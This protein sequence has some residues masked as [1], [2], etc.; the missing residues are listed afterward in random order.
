M[1]FRAQS[2]LLSSITTPLTQRHQQQQP[3]S[4]LVARVVE[5]FSSIFRTASVVADDQVFEG[6]RELMRL[7]EFLVI[8]RKLRELLKVGDVMPDGSV[9]TLAG[10]QPARDWFHLKER[11]RS[12]NM[13]A[14]G[15][16][17]EGAFLDRWCSI[18]LSPGRGWSVDDREACRAIVESL[19]EFS[20]KSDPTSNGGLGADDRRRAD[21]GQAVASTAAGVRALYRSTVHS[22]FRSDEAREKWDKLCEEVDARFPNPPE[23]LRQ[24]EELQVLGMELFYEDAQRAKWQFD[25]FARRL[26]HLTRAKYIPLELPPRHKVVEN[27]RLF[28]ANNLLTMLDIV[29]GA[30]QFTTL[31]GFLSGMRLLMSEEEFDR[32]DLCLVGVRNTINDYL[33]ASAQVPSISSWKPPCLEL[34]VR[35][36]QFV[37]C[38]E[39]H[40]PSLWAIRSHQAV[41]AYK[42]L[43][44]KE[45]A[46][47][48]ATLD[49]DTPLAEGIIRHTPAIVVDEVRQLPSG[50]TTIHFAAWHGNLRLC[51]HLLAKGADVFEKVTSEGLMPFALALERGHLDVAKLLLD[52]AIREYRYQ[53]RHLVYEY[54]SKTLQALDAMMDW[55]IGRSSLQRGEIVRFTRVSE[56]GDKATDA[57]RASNGVGFQLRGRRG[58]VVSLTKDARGPISGFGRSPRKDPKIEMASFT[59]HVAPHYAPF[60]KLLRGLGARLNGPIMARGGTRLHKAATTGKVD[61]VESLCMGRA[62]VNLT[63]LDS[64]TP[65]ALAVRAATA[66]ARLISALLRFGA[67]PSVQ[68]PRDGSQGTSRWSP[69]HCAAS[70]GCIGAVKLLLD[71]RADASMYDEEGT[72]PLHLAVSGNHKPIVS[73]LTHFGKRSLDVN[74]TDKEGN[75]ALDVAMVTPDS[76]ACVEAL[77][78]AGAS[79]S[80]FWYI[81]QGDADEIESLAKRGYVDFAQVNGKGQTPLELA[82][83]MPGFLGKT[84]VQVLERILDTSVS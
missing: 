81:E 29:A 32:H 83:S 15:M 65:L 42:S 61:L 36:C 55:T 3:Y 41:S 23:G 71:F 26:Q 33:S 7:S 20:G 22:C 68:F 38:L 78:C 31:E 39:M 66:D 84:M 44:K 49:D 8:D 72:T 74:A 48:L 50:R 58:G 14:I 73:C 21:E 4:D 80:V 45:R 82:R 10:D 51:Q 56:D 63:D 77:A 17:D 64:M 62:D 6:S 28:H 24:A 25:E 2:A 53:D 69:L 27:C 34:Y 13:T 76:D 54:P 35:V 9:Q 12:S 19:E 43:W 16:I 67:D 52:A 30:L 18:A 11:Q 75:T 70:K 46:L 1:S 59:A 79:H 5:A 47:L 57:N 37:C 60:V 40:L